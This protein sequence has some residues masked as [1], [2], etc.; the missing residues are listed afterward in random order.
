MQERTRNNANIGYLLPPKLNEVEVFPKPNALGVG[1]EVFP[2]ADCVA[3]LVLEAPVAPNGDAP[4]LKEKDGVA[5]DEGAAD[6]GAAAAGAV[7]PP[8]EKLGLGASEDLSEVGAMLPLLPNAKG[9]LVVEAAP[10][11]FPTLEPLL[12]LNPPNPPLRA[13]VGARVDVAPLVEPKTGEAPLGTLNLNFGADA[14]SVGSVGFATAG[15]KLKPDACGLWSSLGVS[16]A[17]VVLAE[18]AFDTPKLN[19]GG[20]GL[21]ACELLEPKTGATLGAMGGVEVVTEDPNTEVGC[22][23][24]NTDG[25]FTDAPL[26]VLDE[27]NT[28][29]VIEA[30]GL[31]LSNDEKGESTGVVL[32]AA[33]NGLAMSLE[34]GLKLPA[35]LLIADVLAPNGP[36]PVASEKFPVVLVVV[37]AGGPPKVNDWVG[38]VETG[39]A[40]LLAGLPKE[41]EEE[42]DVVTLTGGF[43]PNAA[44]RAADWDGCAGVTVGA[45]I[46]VA[47][48]AGDEVPLAKKFGTLSEGVGVDD[49]LA[50][51]I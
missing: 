34:G 8:N 23:E 42:E 38:S 15:A 37:E 51:M 39:G 14:V 49:G 7:L 12:L 2:N 17:G 13:G 5:L 4:P 21:A 29:V 28:E 26:A 47:A 6:A 9:L 35:V 32:L 30:S 31:P 25:G 3:P 10:N 20:V 16:G 41:K 40:G 45:G 50:G 33:P 27:P 46:A 1:V 43:T 44:V 22:E 36:A 48:G 24:P 19:L 11:G 18:G